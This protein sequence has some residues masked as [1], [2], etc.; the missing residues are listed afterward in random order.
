MTRHRQLIVAA[1]GLMS[2][3]LLISAITFARRGP[4]RV[5]WLEPAQPGPPC[6]LPKVAMLVAHAGQLKR[7]RDQ[8]VRDG[9]R[10]GAAG[11]G[12]TACRGCHVHREAFCDRCHEQAG[13]RPDCFGCHDY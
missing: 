5:Q 10:A 7:L 6:I 8:V 9:K 13:V 3:P 11:Q 12:L 1:L 4:A 2:T